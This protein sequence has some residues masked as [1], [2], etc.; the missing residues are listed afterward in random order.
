MRLP[1]LRS[2]P[3]GTVGLLAAAA[4]LAVTGGIDGIIAG[5]ALFGVGLVAPPIITFG[6]GQ[7]AFLAV[8]PS[9]T[10]VQLTA[11][12]VPLFIAFVGTVAAE[13]L[14]LLGGALALFAPLGTMTWLATTHYG[15][16]TAAPGLL[17]A[18][19]LGSYLLHRYERVTLGLAGETA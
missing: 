11:V 6:F 8:V 13:R 5:A 12:N 14:R 3:L 15:P 17:L 16:L 1:R 18:V 7:A 10:P 19:G 2:S 4:A 9:P